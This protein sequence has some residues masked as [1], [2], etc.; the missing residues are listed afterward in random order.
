MFTQL[1]DPLNNLTLTC[2]VALIPVV[3]LLV[4]LAVFRTPAWIAVLAG[5]ILTFALAVWV[6]QM[7]VDVGT[8]AYLNGSATGVWNVDWITFWGLILFNTLSLT[9]LF[10]NFR[11]WL[12]AQGSLDVRVQTMLFAWAFGALL[13]GLVGFGYPWAVVA[14][15][16][17]SLGISDLNAIRVAAIANNAPVSY[18]AL[19]APIIAL[20]AV[21]GYPLLALSG[22]V[23]SVVAVLALLPPWVLLY[24]VSGK[25]GMLSAWPLAVVGSLGYIAGQYPVAVY[26][27]PYLPDV[28]G[29]IVCFASLLLLLKFWQPKTVLGYGGV[30]LDAAALAKGN[31]DHGLKPADVLQA[32]MPF[33]ILLVVVTAWTGPWSPLPKVTWFTTQVV[34]SAP[35][36]KTNITAAFKFAPWVGGTAILASW[37]LVAI[38]LA[39]IGKLNG[40]LVGEIFRKTFQQMWGALLVGVFIFGLAY[41]FNFSGMASSLAKGFSTLGTAFIIVAPILGFIGV[42][43]SGSNT[44]TN[45]MFG[46]FQALVGVQLGFP[47]LLL[48]TLNSVGAEIGK[49]IAPQTASVGVS[50]S[51]FVRREGDVIRHNMGWTFILLAYLIVIAIGFYF[52]HPASMTL[53]PPAP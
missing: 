27:G 4:L 38:W 51:K 18:G 43:L 46:K 15:I 8:Q 11:R 3:F 30:P 49:P 25:Q 12:I 21:T 9:G 34:A 50:T 44:S 1:I 16:L 31:E 37:I 24:L 45:A 28:T 17:I 33:V 47:P 2:L 29:A 39:A 19:G 10:E 26:L 23:G 53:P 48:P 42:A 22:S 20:A 52:L 5:S 14:P 32:W 41:V 7:P 40:K 36:I 6:W 13:E 35:E